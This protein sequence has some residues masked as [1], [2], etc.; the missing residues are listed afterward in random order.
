M[1]RRRYHFD[2]ASL[3]PHAPGGAWSDGYGRYHCRKCGATWQAEKLRPL[4]P[5]RVVFRRYDPRL[6]S[7][8]SRHY[9]EVG[10]DGIE[11]PILA[12]C[13]WLGPIGLRLGPW[14]AA[15]GGAT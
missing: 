12:T 15:K 9:V 5:V 4:W 11:R 14:T 2:P 13:L 1:S 6:Q 8:A 7:F 10:S 3:R